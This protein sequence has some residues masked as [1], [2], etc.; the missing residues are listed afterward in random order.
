MR[1]RVYRL[2]VSAGD[3]GRL[4]LRG[5]AATAR[6]PDGRATL[7]DYEADLDGQDVDPSRVTKSPPG[8]LSF[9]VALRGRGAP[10][11]PGAQGAAIVEPAAGRLAGHALGGAHLEATATG[12]RWGSRAPRRAR[13]WRRA[14]R[15][16]PRRGRARRR[17]RRT[18]DPPRTLARRSAA[19]P[20]AAT[21]RAVAPR[22][23]DLV[24]AEGPLHEARC[25][26]VRA[27]GVRVDDATVEGRLAGSPAA[28]R[29]AT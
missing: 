13:R 7:G 23:R 11:A 4:S 29:E 25:A 18:P 14:A 12:A 24:G 20:R 22:E 27:A 21:A 19:R 26:A 28:P 1:A 6:G 15:G 9:S 3:A 5:G 17:R 8:R 10:L 16:G 2:E